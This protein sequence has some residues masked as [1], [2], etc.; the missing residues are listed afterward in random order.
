MP[1]DP[2]YRRLLRR[3][4]AALCV[5][6]AVVA[7]CY[8][9]VDRPVALF[10]HDHG[11]PSV[12]AFEWLTLPPPV[13]QAWVPAVLAGLAVR[14]A[15]GPFR[16]W[17]RA[18]LAAGAAVVLADQFRQSLGYVFGRYWPATWTHDNPS[19]LRDGDAGY[20]FHPF[21]EGPWYGSFPSGHTARTA[22]AA[23]V[24]W[25]AY[26]R[27]RWLA[28]AAV[29]AVTVGLIGMDYHFVGDVVA[30]GFVGGTVGVYA[31]HLAGAG[32]P[33]GETVASASG[34]R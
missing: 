17:E 13:V 20:G 24:L 3:T 11:L 5:T 27:W 25:V 34:G 28:A 16:R 2:D 21:H 10:V 12:R 31:A 7:L 29:A 8:F 22:A 33:S 1:A 19:F 30:G 23:A 15:W 26:P 6:A 4:L 32:A 9:F 14:R 18:V